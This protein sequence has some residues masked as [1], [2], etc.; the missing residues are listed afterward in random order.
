VAAAEILEVWGQHLHE[1]RPFG[2]SEGT[3]LGWSDGAP[4]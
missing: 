1:V 2:H 4:Q 3:F